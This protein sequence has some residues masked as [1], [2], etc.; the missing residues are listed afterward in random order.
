[1]SVR[2]WQPE[3]FHSAAQ[4][5]LV[6]S[7]ARELVPGQGRNGKIME[8]RSSPEAFFSSFDTLANRA[9]KRGDGAGV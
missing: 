2:P 6:E 5:L 3:H 4:W 8:V 1:M 7:G 9:H